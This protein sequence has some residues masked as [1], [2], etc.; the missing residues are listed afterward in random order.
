MASVTS[1]QR[2]GEEEF[3]YNVMHQKREHVVSIRKTMPMYGNVP[4]IGDIVV[5]CKGTE[6]GRITW[7]GVQH[8]LDK[9]N[10]R[11]REEIDLGRGMKTEYL[12]ELLA[13]VREH[14]KDEKERS[15]TIGMYEDIKRVTE[16]L[17]E[18]IDE[19]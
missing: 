12:K 5:T 7:Y 8:A 10:E 11:L 4:C 3:L 6:L 9:N 2:T 16:A 17:Q 1:M 18:L 19:F 13:A 14:E 15:I